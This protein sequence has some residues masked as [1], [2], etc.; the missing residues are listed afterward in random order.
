MSVLD[1]I[2]G[3]VKVAKYMEI[4]PT[5]LLQTIVKIDRNN[6]DNMLKHYK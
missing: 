6:F 3:T 1:I 4:L 5:N 2:V